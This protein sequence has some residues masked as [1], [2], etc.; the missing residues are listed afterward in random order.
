MDSFASVG[1]WTRTY[2]QKLCMDTGCSLEDL[3]EAMDDRDEWQERVRK[4]HA[5]CMT[6][7]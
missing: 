5:S 4:I 3:L 6:W 2:L 7:S 1:Q